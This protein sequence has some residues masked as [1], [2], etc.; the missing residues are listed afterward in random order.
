M[1]GLHHVTV[2]TFDPKPLLRV[3]RDVVGLPVIREFV[4]PGAAFASLLNVPNAGDVP[5]MM[6]GNGDSGL[7]ELCV[8]DK[9]LEGRVAPGPRLLVFTARSLE[10]VLSGAAAADGVS[11]TEVVDVP[12]LAMQ[13]V[14]VSA[15][16]TDLEFVSF[17]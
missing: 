3:L 12:E 8:L 10:E 1:K 2:L 11:T 17:P 13:S 16:G 6:L 4:A 14:L 5:C 7:I 15:S 9:S